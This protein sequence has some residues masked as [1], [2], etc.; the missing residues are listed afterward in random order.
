MVL[1]LHGLSLVLSLYPVPEDTMAQLTKTSIFHTSSLIFLSISAALQ[2]AAASELSSAVRPLPT[3]GQTFKFSVAVDA[4]K[5]GKAC[6]VRFETNGTTRNETGPEGKLL[7]VTARTRLL[8]GDASCAKSSHAV[9]SYI[10]RDSDGILLRVEE[11]K[12]EDPATCAARAPLPKDTWQSPEDL[13]VCSPAPAEAMNTPWGNRLTKRLHCTPEDAIPGG[14]VAEFEFWSDE[15]LFPVYPHLRM[16][17]TL[18]IPAYGI[19]MTTDTRL[20]GFN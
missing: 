15:S 1:R 20:I 14:G 4:K 8:D 12:T 7:V 11:C 13:L 16:K 2:L 9:K 18:N 17:Q 19:E 5:N 3:P 6:Q 10:Y